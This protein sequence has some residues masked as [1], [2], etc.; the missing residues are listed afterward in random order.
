MATLTDAQLT[1]LS[2]TAQD[3][4]TKYPTVDA[5]QTFVN[6]SVSRPFP[7]EFRAPRAAVAGA[8]GAT[9]PWQHWEAQIK[10]AVCTD[11]NYCS[12]K[13]DVDADLKKYIPK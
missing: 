5:L 9:P 6:N 4:A 13:A 1:L 10:K 11:F 12:K 7:A 8:A 3:L 2:Q